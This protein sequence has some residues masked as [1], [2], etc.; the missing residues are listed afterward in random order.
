MPTTLVGPIRIPQVN[1]NYYVGEP[2]Q[3]NIQQAVSFAIADSNAGNVIISQA[4]T[5]TDSIATVTGGSPTVFIVDER[6]GQRQV[7]YW[8]GANYVAAAFGQNAG[9]IAEG[10]P[11]ATPGSIQM[12]YAPAGDAGNGSGNI[13]IVSNPGEGIPSFNIILEPQG[14]P[15]PG[16]TFIRCALDSTGLPRVESKRLEVYPDP[17]YPDT[18]NMWIGQFPELA[19]NKAMYIWG[20]P[21]ENAVDVQ[22]VTSTG[23]TSTPTYDQTIRL[24]YLG[25]DVNIGMN[26]SVFENG[27]L[28]CEEANVAGSLFATA[29]TASDAEFDECLVDNSPVRTF[30]N[31]PDTGPGDGM[32]WPDVGIAVSLGSSWQSPSIDPA[33]IPRLDVA[34]TF[35]EGQTAQYLV[36]N[37]DFTPNPIIVGGGTVI[38]YDP[39][40]NHARFNSQNATLATVPGLQLIGSNNATAI[41]YLECDP[42]G[43]TFAQ[44]LPVS[45]QGPFYLNY[46]NVTL[47]P[48][49]SPS[50]GGFA[51]GWNSSSGGGET[52]F[53]NSHGGGAGGFNWYNVAG[54][55]SI[56]PST[57]PSM[58][59][60][61][62]GDLAVTGVLST[63]GANSF[64]QAGPGMTGMGIAGQAVPRLA[65]TVNGQS[66]IAYSGEFVFT[67]WSSMT[68][69]SSV[70]DTLDIRHNSAGP[71][72]ESAS[73]WSINRAADMFV[74]GSI[75]AVE[76]FHIENSV[77]ATQVILDNQGNVAGNPNATRLAGINS[78]STTTAAPLNLLG[79]SE[80]FSVT[81]VYLSA[82]HDPATGVWV[83]TV[84]NFGVEGTL[85]TGALIV[86]ANNQLRIGARSGTAW[87][88][89][90][91]NINCDGASVLIN[92]A[93]GSGSV[94]LNW[95]QGNSVQFGNGA[96]VAV[97]TVDG[98]GNAHFAGTLTAGV[99]SFRIT[100]PLDSNKELEHSCIEG[101]EIAVYYRGE[102][103]TENGEIVVEL[104]DYFEALTLPEGRTVQLTQI[105]E[106]DSEAIIGSNTFS[107]LMA[108][109]VKDGKFR[110]RSSEPIAKV[111]WEVM[112]IRADVPPLV[113]ETVK[114][115]PRDAPPPIVHPHPNP[116]P[117]FPHNPEPP[118]PRIVRSGTPEAGKPKP[119]A[120]R[121]GTPT[122][123]GSGR[124]RKPR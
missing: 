68:P 66:G 85:T 46:N 102:T 79:Y 69:S 90:S 64:V 50:A 88:S 2:M 32:L 23:V 44:G 11:P 119:E 109:R 55:T 89:G 22:G 9:F 81:A 124:T 3:R 72:G 37:G 96:G 92:S 40:F 94:F 49:I 82:M 76:A 61:G 17:N 19:G 77:A 110:I 111:Y 57:N 107:M 91:P 24:N 121:A 78:S 116:H 108:S 34:N 7:Y 52:D 21:S 87:G 18:F 73:L 74:A 67:T 28:N 16:S 95:D 80:D 112:A 122:P 12:G 10:M 25:G 53:I 54:G 48:V 120:V 83:S 14:G 51:L 97:G 75:T 115:P 1:T 59:L 70:T 41:V 31:T 117:K 36:A 13:V 106:D 71:D 103:V 45:V 43:A 99:K 101:P 113:I 58:W 4:Y 123:A 38:D 104:P 27:T 118:R 30:A 65:L 86:A 8:N 20:H 15:N 93:A 56:G 62:A 98:S 84:S 60:S 42:T 26:A 114:E 100:H 47:P 35:T 33:T 6:N 5:G 39:A 29:V 105:F 63:Q